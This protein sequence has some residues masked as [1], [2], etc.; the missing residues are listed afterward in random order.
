MYPTS[1]TSS[2][3][4]KS[5]TGNANATVADARRGHQDRAGRSLLEMLN[6]VSPFAGQ[7][8]SSTPPSQ[9]V[10]VISKDL[11]I[12]LQHAR[13]P[14]V[15]PTVATISN[16]LRQQAEA[17]AELF[18]LYSYASTEMPNNGSE[19]LAHRIC[20]EIE[21]RDLAMLKK[22]L[23]KHLPLQ[24]RVLKFKLKYDVLMSSP[25][26]P[27]AACLSVSDLRVKILGAI[28]RRRDIE[29]GPPPTFKNWGVMWRGFFGRPTT[30][31]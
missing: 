5:V 26:G 23:E 21:S 19:V 14:V 16:Q 8:V 20:E 13:V 1:S 22:I 17:I 6:S 27:K 25:E 3:I 9:E 10:P 4:P 31:V 11:S 12:K 18:F 7:P 24:N 28:E 2:I 29:D 15:T 30:S